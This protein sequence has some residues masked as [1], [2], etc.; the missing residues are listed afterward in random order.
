M[1]FFWV[2]LFAFDGK[3]ARQIQNKLIKWIAIAC[4]VIASNFSDWGI[5]APLWA[6]CFYLFK[7]KKVAQVVS[8][9]I[10]TVLVI[11]VKYIIIN[12]YDLTNIL[13]Q[14][15]LFLFI[16]MLYIYNGKKGKAS[17]FNKWF[18]FSS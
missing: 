14:L 7:E 15:G 13:I 3:P 11:I 1:V 8:Y 12:N 2:C 9:Y 6:L 17:K 18:L 4:L 16:P 5:F 10:V